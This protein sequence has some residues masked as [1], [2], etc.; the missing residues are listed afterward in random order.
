MFHK[1]IL[2][3]AALASI[4]GIIFFLID[5]FGKNE[6]KLI[7]PYITWGLIVGGVLIAIIFAL[8]DKSENG[9]KKAKVSIGSPDNSGVIIG[10]GDSME[11]DIN[12][13]Q[14]DLSTSASKRYKDAL[15]IVKQEAGQNFL[16]LGTLIKAVENHPPRLF[17]DKRRPNESEISFQ[18]RAK[19]FHKNYSDEIRYIVGKFPIST[20][21]YTIHRKDLSYNADVAIRIKESYNYQKEVIAS[22]NDFTDHITQNL[23]F[24]SSETEILENNKSSYEEKI[25]ASKIEFF[26]AAAQ[27]VLILND[28]D[29]DIFK[30]YVK[31]LDYKIINNKPNEIW[32]EFNKVIATL[33]K[34]KSELLGKRITIKKESEQREIERVI[35]D[36]YLVMLRKAM[37]MKA[38]LSEGE[39]IGIKNKKIDENENNPEKLLSLAAFSFIESDG[40]ASAFYLQKALQ[41]SNLSEL[42]KLFISLSLKRVQEPDIYEGSI[43]VMIFDLTDNGEAKSYGLEQ[44]DVIY[45]VNGELVYEPLDI[46]SII[47]KTSK[48]DDNLFELKRGNKIKRIAL[49]G[50]NSLN[51]K[52][53]QLIILNAVQL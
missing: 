16:N 18:D 48:D 19:E 43:G 5:K 11:G 2:W 25:L 28:T 6:G 27:Y 42:Q 44:G 46:S 10:V 33:Y 22:I 24:Y 17:W 26:Q 41:S 53:T 23:K 14:G 36:P 1:T 21:D 4:L 37:G 51:C 50:G 29:L 13:N 7:S 34:Q 49:R 12:V 52:A 40:S 35:K 45:K 32:Q 9:E 47:G 38:E 15:D 31:S 20:S 39:F 3:I 30:E 8:T